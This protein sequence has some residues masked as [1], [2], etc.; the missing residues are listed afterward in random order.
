MKKIVLIVITSTLLQIAVA[1]EKKNENKRF[2]HHFRGTSNPAEFFYL[3]APKEQPNQEEQAI[4]EMW[5]D[6]TQEGLDAL[7]ASNT[8]NSQTI[9]LKTGWC[10]SSYK[11]TIDYNNRV[12]RT[13]TVTHR[14][15]ER[16]FDHMN[17]LLTALFVKKIPKECRS[18]IAAL[19]FQSF[20]YSNN[21]RTDLLKTENSKSKNLVTD[22]DNK[23]EQSK[24]KNEEPSQQN[25]NSNSPS[26]TYLNIPEHNSSS[27]PSP[28]Q[29]PRN[30]E[31]L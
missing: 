28:Q 20:A 9:K 22:D 5:K 31:S 3:L 24:S 26:S 13:Q 12:V 15:V 21:N 27:N 8:Q 18:D 14:T 19:T 30:G 6:K 2:A 10:C 4:E 1:S 17:T 23:S 16:S 25:S 11:A 7:A 29:S